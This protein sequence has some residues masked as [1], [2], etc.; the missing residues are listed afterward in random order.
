[1]A[2]GK[3]A[4]QQCCVI[5]RLQQLAHTHF[6]PFYRTNEV[7][8]FNTK[9]TRGC[10]N[11]FAEKENNISHALQ[12]S[13]SD[14][15]F[16]AKLGGRK[17]KKKQSTPSTISQIITEQKHLKNRHKES[18]HT[19]ALNKSKATI[20]ELNQLQTSNTHTYNCTDKTG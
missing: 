4:E 9:H 7:I 19:K 5:L 14:K 6:K 1:M 11:Q 13:H 10:K 12:D 15:H 3:T 18:H 8:I 17:R 20:K 16:K 2:G